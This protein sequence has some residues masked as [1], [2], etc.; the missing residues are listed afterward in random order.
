MFQAMAEKAGVRSHPSI[1]RAVELFD[2][3]AHPQWQSDSPPKIDWPDDWDIDPPDSWSGD[4]DAALNSPIADAI[5]YLSHEGSDM[6]Q[7]IAA[8]LH[9][10]VEGVVS[11]IKDKAGF[12]PRT[13]NIPHRDAWET[14]PAAARDAVHGMSWAALDL[15]QDM[16]FANFMLRRDLRAAVYRRVCSDLYALADSPYFT[17]RTGQH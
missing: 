10:T 1:T 13:V 4:A 14:D 7:T 9:S 3:I 16:H 12:R 15:A 6:A 11:E 17:R 8:R 5:E 2:K